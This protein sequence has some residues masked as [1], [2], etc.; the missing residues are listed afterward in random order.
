[1]EAL[2]RGL[3]VQALLEKAVDLYLAGGMPYAIPAV[4]PGRFDED[5]A[6]LEKILKNGTDDMKRGIRSSLEAFI[7]QLRTLSPS[8]RSGARRRGTV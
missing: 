1:M 4:S 5:H 7:A 8:Q 2:K 6:K 3:K